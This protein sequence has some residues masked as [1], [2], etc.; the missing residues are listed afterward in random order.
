MTS[1]DIESFF[2]V[3]NE[4][5]RIIYKII[6]GVDEFPQSGIDSISRGKK[7]FKVCFWRLFCMN[8]REYHIEIPFD[9]V[10]DKKIQKKFIKE[11]IKNLQ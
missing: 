3:Q 10:I 9:A 5:K 11:H 4:I 6:A 7:S 1:N 8:Y 2:K